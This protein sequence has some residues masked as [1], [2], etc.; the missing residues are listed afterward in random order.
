MVA[1][2][3]DFPVFLERERHRTVLASND[4]YPITFLASQFSFVGKDQSS[5]GE[6]WALEVLYPEEEVSAEF[7]HAQ[8][9]LRVLLVGEIA[10]CGRSSHYAGFHQMF[11][12]HLIALWRIK[13]VAVYVE[14]VFPSCMLKSAAACVAA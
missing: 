1:Y 3:L 2:E 10:P 4:V 8:A 6:L 12:H 14:V 5:H 11:Q 7:K 13:R 9:Q